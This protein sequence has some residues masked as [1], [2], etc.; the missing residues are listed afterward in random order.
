MMYPPSTASTAPDHRSPVLVAFSIP[1]FPPQPVL[2]S[3]FLVAPFGHDL[4]YRAARRPEL[5]R[6]D[7]GIADD[8]A[9]VAANLLF[10]RL[11]IVDFDGEVMDAG[12]FPRRGRLR[13]LRIVVVAHDRDVER[14]IGQVA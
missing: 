5:H 14:P 11:E 10:R 1:C 12:P 4:A 7:A 3:G 13:R 6:N 2:F 9:A 8:L